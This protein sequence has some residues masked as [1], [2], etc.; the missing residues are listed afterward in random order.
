MKLYFIRH[1][2]T[3]TNLKKSAV[4]FNDQLTSVGRKQA[5]LLAERFSHLSIDLV[6]TSPHKRAKET[7]EILAGRVSKKIQVLDLLSERKWPTEIEGKALDDPEVE[8][9]FK[10]MREKVNDSTWHYSDEENFPDVRNRANMFIEYISKLTLENILTV[11]HEYFIKVVI[12]VMMHGD[13]L[14]Y[15]IFRNFFHF[16][17]LSNASTTLCEREHNT[18]K[19]ITLNDQQHFS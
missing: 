1:G 12:A 18:W 11:S 17:T 9:I 8:K 6:L 14:S 16:T 5:E 7:A 19:L 13:Q 4:S 15:E 2:E 3:E 10:M